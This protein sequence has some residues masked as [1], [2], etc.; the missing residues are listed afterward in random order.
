MIKKKCIWEIRT[1][2][3]SREN[4]ECYP[5]DLPSQK[6]WLEMASDNQS[7]IFTTLLPQNF[8][9]QF[10]FDRERE[11]AGWFTAMIKQISTL[12][13]GWLSIRNNSSLC[14]YCWVNMLTSWCI[15]LRNFC[16]FPFESEEERKIERQRQILFI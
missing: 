11:C 6:A 10:F 13:Q 4:L 16:S 15:L 12:F 3:P 8:L 5:L 1:D 9:S 2:N 14:N 7:R